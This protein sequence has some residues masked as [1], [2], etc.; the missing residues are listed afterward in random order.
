MNGSK[1][2]DPRF[3]RKWQASGAL[4]SILPVD[5]SL[6][7]QNLKARE[8]RRQSDLKLQEERRQADLKRQ[9]ALREDK[10]NLKVYE[11]ACAEALAK[12][13]AAP[14]ELNEAAQQVYAQAGNAALLDLQGKRQKLGLC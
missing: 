7:E 4:G 14:R 12:Y 6:G 11:A 1:K 3:W 5:S 9:A 10:E 8:V 13:N 2:N